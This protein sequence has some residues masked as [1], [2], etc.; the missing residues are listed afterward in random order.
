MS[1]A[2]RKL[3][4]LGQDAKEKLFFKV[5]GCDR[6]WD[7]E[8]KTYFLGILGSQVHLIEIA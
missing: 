7:R 1:S 2:L 4:T 5:A 6:E 3:S 8:K